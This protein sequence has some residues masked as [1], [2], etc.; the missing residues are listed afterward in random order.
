MKVLVV[1]EYPGRKQLPVMDLEL[2]LISKDPVSKCR[3]HVNTAEAL[4]NREHG[5]RVRV[6]RSSK[7]GAVVAQT[8]CLRMKQVGSGPRRP[9]YIA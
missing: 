9:C 7:S 1:G 6:A 2:E 4:W 5:S 3:F 8:N